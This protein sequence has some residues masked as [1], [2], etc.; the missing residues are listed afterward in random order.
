MKLLPI[1][2]YSFWLKTK[3]AYHAFPFP[4]GLKRFLLRQTSTVRRLLV[5]IAATRFPEPLSY[6]ADINKVIRSLNIAT[7]PAPIISLIIPCYGQLRYTL[8]CLL[9]IEQ[10]KPNL[11]L[12]II[13]VDDAS[14][15]SEYDILASVPGLRILRNDSNLGFIGSCNAG[16]S[17]ANGEYLHFL[18][19]DTCLT[20]G[21]IEELLNTLRLFPQCGVVGSQL[22][23][24][25]GKLQEAGAVLLADASAINVGRFDDPNSSE[26]AYLRIVD[27]CSGASIMVRRDQFLSLGGF[28]AF[29]SPAYYEDA[30][31]CLRYSQRGLCTLYQ[32]LSRVV[33]FEG[34]S[35]GLSENSGIKAYQAVNQSRLHGRWRDVLFSHQAANFA[36]L[37]LPRGACGRVLLITNQI[38]HPDTDAGSICEINLMLLLRAAGWQPTLLPECCAGYE[39]GYSELCQGLGIELAY[40]SS[41]S[42][43]KSW[44]RKRS[45]AFDL[46]V[47]FRPETCHERLPLIRR[48]CPRAKVIYYPHDLHY[49]RFQRESELLGQSDYMQRAENYRLVEHANSRKADLTVLLSE[50]ERQILGSAL[51]E[52]LL[53]T[54]PLVLAEASAYSSRSPSARARDII[55]MGNFRHSPNQDAVSFF[56]AEI[57]PRILLEWHD[58]VFHVVGPGAPPHILALDS[59][60]ICIHGFVEDLDAFLSQMHVSVLPL[61]FGAGV[62]GKLMASLRAAL[63]VVSTTLGIEGVPINPGCE[64]LVADQP[65]AF[66]EAVLR[67]LAD[68]ELRESLGMAGL[69]ASKALWSS[70]L[71]YRHLAEILDRLGLPTHSQPAQD[72]IPLYPLERSTWPGSHCAG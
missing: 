36:D 1:D 3:R 58:A 20:R 41:F 31:L 33:H 5:P 9:S 4:F 42:S 8:Q 56:V 21:S 40:P 51:P 64:V 11:D 19:N 53:A 27:Y 15:D 26:Y 62:K 61:R 60:Q 47:L 10:F 70:S 68:P 32:P 71:A 30:D 50:K 59:E 6:S 25:N 29:F 48:Y 14:P 49:L 38:P 44:L 43:L 45:S 17:I 37:S 57:L 2:R 46:V 39:P 18:N 55:F 52:A 28:D 13:V 54:L 69:Q 35:N 7:C 22:L 66:A 23:Y 65:A 72:P 34:V 12:E 16:A 67:L 24:P 63:P